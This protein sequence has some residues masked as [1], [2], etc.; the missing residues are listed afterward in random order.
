M[1]YVSI[2]DN[3]CLL[4]DRPELLKSVDP[5]IDVDKLEFKL[6]LYGYCPHRTAYLCDGFRNGFDPGYRGPIISTTCENMASARFR[7]HIMRDLINTELAAGR[8]LGPFQTQ[9]FKFMHINAIGFV[10]KKEPNKYRLI[11]DLS[12]PA[13]LSVNYFIPRSH[14]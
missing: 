3:P 7:P 13:G 12:R 8:F 9:P 14:S 1:F 10:P 4:P 11:V 6:K 2:V 5:V